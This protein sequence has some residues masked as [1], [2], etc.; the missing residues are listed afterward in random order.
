MKDNDF[1]QRVRNH[2]GQRVIFCRGGV[3]TKDRVIFCRGGVVTKDR[4]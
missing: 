1:L 3:V 2:K 4:E